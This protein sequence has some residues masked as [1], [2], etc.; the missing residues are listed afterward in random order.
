M[1][2]ISVLD[3]MRIVLVGT[4]ALLMGALI[5]RIIY[6]RRFL[7][8][9]QKAFAVAM[10]FLLA[11]VA[12]DTAL[13]VT[14]QLT[15]S[16]RLIPCA[17]GIVALVVYFFEPFE[18][19]EKRFGSIPI[20]PEPVEE[21]VE[22]HEIRELILAREELRDKL[23]ETARRSNEKALQLAEARAKARELAAELERVRLKEEADSHGPS[24]A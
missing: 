2:D 4:I 6:V 14:S 24:L 18:K 12:W 21:L 3:A 5:L 10:L 7:T 19:V 11:T 13:F 16:W 17:L 1:T 15:F 20:A 23:Y 8:R 22:S 9:A